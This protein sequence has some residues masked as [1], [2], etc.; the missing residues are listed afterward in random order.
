[1]MNKTRT[2]QE[3]FNNVINFASESLCK[4]YETL[5]KDDV[6]DVK[7]FEQ[8]KEDI[9]KVEKEVFPEK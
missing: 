1:M 9:E 2:L 6:E 5:N 8:M 4:L 7:N 3:R